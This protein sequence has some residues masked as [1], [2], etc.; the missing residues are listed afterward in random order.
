MKYYKIVK[1]DEFV[2]V[3]SSANFVR[4]HRKRMMLQ[5][6]NETEGQ[7]ISYN[8]KL[9]RATWMQPLPDVQYNFEEV[10]VEEISKELY[11]KFS[12]AI[13]NEEVIDYNP[14]VV[15]YTKVIDPVETWSL[16]YARQ[17]K[18]AALGTACTKAIEDGITVDDHH[19]SL[20]ITDQLNL[21]A[22]ENAVNNGA[23]VMYHADGEDYRLFT[24]EEIRAIVVAAAN[25]RIYNTTYYK[26]LKAYINSLDDVGTILA[27][28]YG[29]IVPEEYKS[30]ALKQLEQE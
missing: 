13:E 29:D 8:G 6:V 23:D 26:A 21:L 16:E 22:A 27:I 2:G 12:A 4:K 15:T 17:V 18:I 11:D 5:H 14:P 20:A 24:A 1:D 30:D 25:W 10:G 9:Y 3:V 7:F 28:N 19:Y